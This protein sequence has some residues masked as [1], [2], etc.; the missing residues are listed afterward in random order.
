MDVYQKE[1]IL[2]NRRE[3]KL[4][5][6][7]EEAYQ[8]VQVSL[9]NNRLKEDFSDQAVEELVDETV[10]YLAIHSDLNLRVEE[11]E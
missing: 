9:R 1:K 4:K 6:F 2:N 3:E 5:Q 8:H 11:M 7:A 10:L